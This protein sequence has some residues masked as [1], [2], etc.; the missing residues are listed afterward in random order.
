MS[1]EIDLKLIE[2]AADTGQPDLCLSCLDLRS[3]PP[4]IGKLTNLREL[5]L[6]DNQLTSLPPGDR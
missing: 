1:Q 3:L 2:L 4:E 5:R 6:D